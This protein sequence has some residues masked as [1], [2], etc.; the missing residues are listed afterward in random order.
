MK[1]VITV[2]FLLVYFLGNLPCFAIDWRELKTPS[3]IEFLID[4][5]SLL[6]KNGYYFYN[7][8]IPSMQ[9][10]DFEVIT[11]QSS[12]NNAFSARIAFYSSVEYDKLLGDY[13]NITKNQTKKLEMVSYDSR[14]YTAYNFVKKY[15]GI[16]DLQI[17][18]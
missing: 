15:F 5:D 7:L 8:K 13:Q 18:I 14:V 12:K 6:N 11:I 16:D 1:N 2:I 17:K 10:K 4:L 9:N 3:G